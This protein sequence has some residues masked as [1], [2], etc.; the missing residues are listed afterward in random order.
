MI[1]V[2]PECGYDMRRMGGLEN[3]PATRKWMRWR[4]C[5]ELSGQSTT[6]S[7]IFTILGF[8][9]GPFRRIEFRQQNEAGALALGKS[10]ADFSMK[11]SQAP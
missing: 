2:N 7:S 6:L 5:A 10:L 9:I 1:I 8:V 11:S 4:R 3:G